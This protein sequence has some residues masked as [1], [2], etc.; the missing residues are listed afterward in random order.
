[1]ATSGCLSVVK[2][3]VVES[4]IIEDIP[5][6][7][8]ATVSEVDK[9]K[10]NKFEKFWE[11]YGFKKEKK[12]SEVNFMKL[13]DSQ[14]SEMASKVGKYV[15]NTFVDGTYPSRMYPARYLNPKQ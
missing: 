10:K 13:S 11:F 9:E 5:L 7:Q 4:S 2:C 14:I 8:E 3:S 15:D 12:K 1:M 6:F